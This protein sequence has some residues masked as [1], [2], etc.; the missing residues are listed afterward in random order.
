MRI[1]RFVPRFIDAFFP[2]LGMS[3][4]ELLEH[5]GAQSVRSRAVP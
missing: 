4:L 3:A 1:D 2:H 5:H